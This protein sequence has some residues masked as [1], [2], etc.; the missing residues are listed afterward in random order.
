[1]NS[2]EQKIEQTELP[3]LSEMPAIEK[4]RN[5][6]IAKREE[7]KDYVE[8]PLLA[9]CEMLWDNNIRTIS[10]SANQN[11]IE[12]GEAQIVIDFDSLS[13]ENKEIAAQFAGPVEYDKGQAVIFSF[14]VS[15]STL[16]ESISQKAEAVASA[17][18]HQ[19]AT[20]IPKYTVEDLKNWYGFPAEGSEFDD[21]NAWED[22]FYDPVEKVFYLSE[23]HYK[24]AHEKWMKVN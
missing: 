16:P 14:P 4:S 9:A 24:K 11:D 8:K 2:F 15:K 23:E 3:P 20:W 1:M 18:K 12:R 6:M 19:P 10:T 7:I 17:F 5:E 21:P 22:Y 13:E